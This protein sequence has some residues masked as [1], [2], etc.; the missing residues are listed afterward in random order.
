MKQGRVFGAAWHGRIGC[1]SRSQIEGIETWMAFASPQAPPTE[2]AKADPRL[3][4]LKHE[5]PNESDADMENVAKADPR[6]RGL[7]HYRVVLPHTLTHI[8]LQKQIPD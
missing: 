3:R 1:K 8:L 5:M 2:V 4:G 6:L 7:K